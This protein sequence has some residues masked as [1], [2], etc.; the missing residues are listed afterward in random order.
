MLALKI[1]EIVL[2]IFAI[3]GVG[4]VYGKN[5]RPDMTIPNQLTM[6]VFVPCLLFS[7]LSKQSIMVDQDL[8]LI[9]ATTLIILI[10]GILVWPICRLLK[11]Q[12]KTFC[13]PMM[14]SNAGNMG[15][16]LIVLAFG[17]EALPAA[18]M[19]FLAENTLHFSLG[20]WLL[21]HKA[22]ILQVLVSPSVLASGLAITLGGIGLEINSTL[23]LPVDMLGQI[24]VPFMLFSLGVRLADVDLNEW[25]LGFI[26]AVLSPLV[27]TSTALLLIAVLDLTPIQQGA[28]FMFGALPPAVLNFLF[29]ERYRQEPSR[30]ASIVLIG[31]AFSAISIPLAL[32]YA[33]PRF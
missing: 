4:L 17:D 16:P 12:V 18:V 11:V 5:Y 31:N 19:I 26:G 24:C 13:P 8:Q 15:L 27:G 3:V 23:R 2:P 10:S 32:A 30:V 33:L 20:V 29:A 1:L 14:F 9:V 21:N 28:L 22:N 7:V 25:R 6:A